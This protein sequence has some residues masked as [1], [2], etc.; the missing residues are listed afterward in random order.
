M[1]KI[2]ELSADNDFPVALRGVKIGEKKYILLWV[3]NEQVA[4]PAIRVPEFKKYL[5]DFM[6]MKCPKNG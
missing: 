6:D 3:D 5:V 4:I 1:D 2:T